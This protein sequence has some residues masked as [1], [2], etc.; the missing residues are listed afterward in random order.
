[1]NKM[2]S[3][4]RSLGSEVVVFQSLHGVHGDS[5]KKTDV[6]DASFV[7]SA[8]SNIS[9]SSGKTQAESPASLVNFF[10]TFSCAFVEFVFTS[11]GGFAFL[12]LIRAIFL[13]TLNQLGRLA[14][15]D[16]EQEEKDK[17]GFNHKK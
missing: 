17:G 7:N 12:V 4:W 14:E 13:D 1:M 2:I 16:C 9:S 6:F 11:F 3:R 10:T 15:A 8:K 5:V